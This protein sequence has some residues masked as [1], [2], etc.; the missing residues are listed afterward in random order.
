MPRLPGTHIRKRPY[1]ENPLEVQT[2][3][4]AACTTLHI[5]IC[6][7]NFVPPPKTRSRGEVGRR[8]RRLGRIDSFS[9]EHTEP[10]PGW[11][12]AGGA[13]RAGEQGEGA[14]SHLPQPLPA[15]RRR[16][17]WSPASARPFI[18]GCPLFPPRPSTAGPRLPSAENE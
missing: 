10:F 2:R 1:R 12:Q 7:L 3:Q 6:L 9:R 5:G 11:Q 13:A 17:Q 18:R 14:R 8:Q 4:L 15:P 16:A